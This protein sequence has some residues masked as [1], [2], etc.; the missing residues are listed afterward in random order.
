MTRHSFRFSMLLLGAVAVT[1]G[2]CRRGSTGNLAPVEGT[3][4]KGGRPLRGIEVVFL[5][6]AGTAGPRAIGTTDEAGHYCLRTDQGD[7]GAVAGKYRV[8]LH[9]V[10]ATTKQMRSRLRSQQK[11]GMVES[12]EERLKTRAA[13]PRVPPRF[14]SFNETPLR[15]EVG[16]EPQPLNFDFP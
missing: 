4:S 8:V 9:D 15:A 2:G 3:V 5:P 10:E 11:K 16:P 13:A 6:D 12:L 1:V 14:G 7:V